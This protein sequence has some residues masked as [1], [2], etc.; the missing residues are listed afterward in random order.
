MQAWNY[1]ELGRFY[2]DIIIFENSEGEKKIILKTLRKR[3]I[4]NIIKNIRMALFLNSLFFSVPYYYFN[5]EFQTNL[6]LMK[7]ALKNN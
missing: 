4:E 5:S 1:N 3:N 2:K 6:H 7:S